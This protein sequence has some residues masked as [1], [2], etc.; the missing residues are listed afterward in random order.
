MQDHP[1]RATPK[2]QFDLLLASSIRLQQGFV[3][4]GFKVAA[5][6]TVFLGWLLTADSAHAFIKGAPRFLW[7]FCLVLGSIGTVTILIGMF[8]AR[9]EAHEVFGKLCALDY[10]DESMLTQH[11][12]KPRLFWSVALLNGSICLMLLLGMCVV[13]ITR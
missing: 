6:L 2:E 4:T 10:V 3:E 11:H 12:L 7:L 9:K 5:A 13:R 1:N 8:Q